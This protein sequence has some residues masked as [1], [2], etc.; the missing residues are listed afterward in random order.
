MHF[1]VSNIINSRFFSIDEN[2]I[3]TFDNN[4]QLNVALSILGAGSGS[5]PIKDRNG[6]YGGVSSQSTFAQWTS[7]SSNKPQVLPSTESWDCYGKIFYRNHENS[8]KLSF[9]NCKIL[10]HW[11]D[12]IKKLLK[13]L[14][15]VKIIFISSI[16]CNFALSLLLFCKEFENL[17]KIALELSSSLNVFQKWELKDLINELSKQG[18]FS[19]H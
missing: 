4:Y 3:N 6:F 5:K 17:Q 16:E 12:M 13:Y 8:C 11:N 18:K 2:A 19:N 15:N 14:N 7:Y 10:M 9:K 1:I